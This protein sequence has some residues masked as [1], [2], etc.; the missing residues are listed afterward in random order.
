MR[1]PGKSMIKLSIITIN[2]NN[3]T[4]LKKTVESVLSQTS[5]DFNYIIVDGGSTDGSAD[6]I[7]NLTKSGLNVS[8]QWISES[9][10]GIYHAMNKGIKIATGEFVQ[11]VNSGDILFDK[12]VIAKMLA[13]INFSDQIIYG[14][15]IKPLPK[16]MFRDKAFQ[17]RKPTFLDFYYGTL[18]HSPA[19]IR[20]SLFEK[21]GYYDENLR[22]VSDWKWYLLTIILSDIPI[23]YIPVDVTLFDMSGISNSNRTLEIEERNKVLKD[24]ISVNILQDYLDNA[25]GLLSYQRIKKFRTGYKLFI[26]FDRFYSWLERKKINK[27]YI[28]K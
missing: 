20:R 1:N 26:L 22:I 16:G 10:N 21:F 18:N 28:R 14:N 4:G 23:R 3:L 2:F 17:G 19:L 25:Y 13:T 7:Q 6:F 24:L 15:M 11:F 8:L 9:D 5:L 27:N 12:N